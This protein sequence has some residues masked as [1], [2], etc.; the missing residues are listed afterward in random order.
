MW[1][2][3]ILFPGLPSGSPQCEYP[4]VHFDCSTAPPGA[5]GTECQRSCSTADMACVS[6]AQLCQFG[7]VLKCAVHAQVLLDLLSPFIFTL[8]GHRSTQAVHQAAYA[9]MVCCQMEPEA[10]SLR[11][12]VHV[13]TTD[14]STSLERRW[15]WIAIPGLYIS[16]QAFKDVYLNIQQQYIGY[17]K[18]L[19]TFPL[20]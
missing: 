19:H 17:K 13:Y 1:S 12:A 18:N 15:Q 2:C 6:T 20:K 5:A 10:A 7:C 16:L 4:M 3:Y 11:A 14:K 8:V 9:P